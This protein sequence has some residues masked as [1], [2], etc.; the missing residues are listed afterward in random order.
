MVASLGLVLV[1]LRA[2]LVVRRARAARRPP[3][4]DARRRHLRVAK[5]ALACI[6]VGLVAGPVSAVWLRGWEAF[7]TLHAA[8]GIGAALCFVVAAIAGRRL[9]GGRMQARNAHALF[10]A[11]AVLIASVAAMAGFVLLP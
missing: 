2:G 1:A 6:L 9:E 8:L 5:P 3:P 10:A 7:G 11:L 4:R